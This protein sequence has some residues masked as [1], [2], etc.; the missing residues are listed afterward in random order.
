MNIPTT[1]L[2]VCALALGIVTAAHSHG[3]QAQTDTNDIGTTNKFIGWWELGGFYGTDD[4]SRGEIVLFTPLMQSATTLFFLDARGKLFEEDVQEANLALGYRQMLPS[5]WNLGLWAGWDIRDTEEDNTFHQVSFGVEALSERFDVRVNGYVPVTDPKSSPG[6]A[7]V[8]LQGNNIFLIGGEEV[9][10][11]GV[12]G[13]VGI[14][15]FG[16]TRGGGLKGAP[17]AAKRHELRAYAGGFWFDADDALEEVAG[18]KG[19]LEYRINDIV[20][21]LPGSRLT[22]ESELSYDEVRDTKF[23]IGA[24]LRIPFGSRGSVAALRTASLTP[25]ELR[26]ID[27]LERDTDIVTVQSKEENVFDILTG[28]T[29]DRADVVQGGGNLQGTL[30]ANGA[31]SLIIL[32]GGETNGNFQVGPNQTLQGGASTIRVVGVKSGTAADFTAP[33]AKPFIVSNLNQAIL[34]V[35]NNTHLAGLGIEGG[36]AA[37]AGNTGI[38]AAADGVSNVAITDTT[39][40]GTGGSG[41]RFFSDHNKILIDGVNIQDAGSR[42]IEFDNNNSNV[43]IRNA[44]IEN[45][46]AEGIRFDDD[47]SKVAITDV[48][49]DNAGSDGGFSDGILFSDG[50]RNVS[51]TQTSIANV[52]DGI[53]FNNNNSNITIAHADIANVDEGIQFRSGNSDIRIDHTTITDAERGIRF[54]NRNNDVRIRYTTIANVND[55]GIDFRDNNTN[56][57]I[58][59]VT[60]NNSGSS[61]IAFNDDNTNIAI[62]NTLVDGTDGESISFT[63][64]NSNITI[65]TVTVRNSNNDGI[66]FDARNTNVVIVNATV[67]NID[68]DGINFDGDN[69]NVTIANSTVT[70]VGGGGIDFDGDGNSNVTIVNNVLTNIDDDGIEFADNN[71]DIVITGNTITDVGTDALNFDANNTVTID[72]NIFAGTIGDDLLDVDGAGNTIN[73][74]GNINNA[75]IGD[76]LC[77]GAGN[78]VGTLEIGGIVIVDAGPPC[79]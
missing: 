17:V 26:M 28:V 75:I 22:L 5:G 57:R 53:E 29:F 23:E 18:P 47:N 39:T 78:F 44:T 6:L 71:T 35:D 32:D 15:L 77:E 43:T 52:E 66:D 34:T 24:R 70:N 56:V 59:H 79:V 36:L 37:G 64:D 40:D 76:N 14:L 20:S 62:L 41:I 3:A 74:A 42:G 50:N 58:D 25:Q 63:D 2:R 69:A 61:A 55:N 13:E 33:G 11:Y 10:L 67:E 45:T 4:S 8:V 46:S 21:S 72:D 49:I 19:R 12:D 65:D 16:R 73:G 9:P 48:R 7:E 30:D 68:A 54:R 51:I 38:E 60:I 27:G 31:N 1:I